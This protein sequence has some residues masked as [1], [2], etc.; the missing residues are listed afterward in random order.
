MSASS[1]LA[2]T[3]KLA[4]C[5]AAGVLL[6]PILLGSACAQQQAAQQPVQ[7][8][9][10]GDYARQHRSEKSAEVVIY[11]ED[12]DRLFQNMDKITKFSAED[13]GFQ[14]LTPIPRRLIGKTECEKHFREEG[15][16]E[17]KHGHRIDESEVVLKKFGLLPASFNL[18][19]QLGDITLSG[20]AGFYDPMDRTMYLLNWIDPDMQKMVMAHELT[21]ALQDQNFHLL[22]FDV[23]PK[24]K[25]G[26]KKEMKGKDSKE[27]MMLAR[28]AIVEGQATLVGEDYDARKYGISLKDEWVRDMAT[29]YLQSTYEFPVT[30]HNA[31]RLLRE[32]MIFPYREGLIFELAVYAKGGREM[33]FRSAF[34]RPPADTHQI[35]QPESYL[36]HEPVARVTI[37]D[38]API[39]GKEYEAYDAGSVGE[40]DVQVMSEDFG[41]ENDIYSVAREWNGGS[42]V[43]VKRAG[44]A[45]GSEVKTADLALVYVSRWTT[46]KAAERFSQ[47]YLDG[48]NKRMTLT[49]LKKDHCIE[50]PCPRA[51]W[52]AHAT[53][54]E[55]PVHIELWPGNVV[56]VTQSV[57]D[58]RV[59]AMR[60]LLL[61]GAK[62]SH[63]PAVQKEA[64]E[65]EAAPPDAA[66]P[67]PEDQD[68]TQAEL[69]QPDLASRLFAMPKFS[70]LS[71]QL[72]LDIGAKLHQELDRRQR[73]H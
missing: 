20:L 11:G 25:P 23:L 2:R 58:A 60:P 39:F 18:D 45:A 49:D 13:S 17:A 7:Q 63:V 62:S 61:A 53:S 71:H 4:C 65:K 9:S 14:K 31:P 1:F 22:N 69:T 21:H 46:R 40:F 72:G 19:E 10:L 51:L 47:I 34:S 66:A 36:K 67:E 26:E 57:D 59:K 73:E 6:L 54:P 56:I 29:S 5:A 16:D 33:A 35:L 68:P 3:G 70:A 48:L 43:A 44:L 12:V 27:E 32:S 64:T 15:E 28:R 41:R 42:Y 37:G 30:L 55:G 52:E 8:Q 50:E 24:A 38:L